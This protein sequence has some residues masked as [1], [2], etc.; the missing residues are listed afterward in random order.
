[1]ADIKA[2]VVYACGLN[3]NPVIEL[4]RLTIMKNSQGQY[5]PAIRANALALNNQEYAV[6]FPV[7]SF[8]VSNE[9]QLEEA[10][11]LFHQR[12]DRT[13]DEYKERWAKMQDTSGKPKTVK[14]AI[15]EKKAKPALVEEPEEL[16]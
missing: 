5:M 14:E 6:K 2:S 11:K 8:D 4:D 9:E 1:M 10:R 13:F 16:S 15:E 12:L 3:P 7:F